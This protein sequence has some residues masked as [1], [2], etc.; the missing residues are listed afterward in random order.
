M[1]QDAEIEDLIQKE[2]D[3]T[4]TQAEA[5]KLEHLI[6]NNPDIRQQLSQSLWLHGQLSADPD[7]INACLE[8]TPDVA[9]NNITYLVFKSFL[10]LAAAVL[11]V[12]IGS[13]L[14]PTPLS[15]A[16]ATLV[17]AE[18]CTWG[19][20]EL[21]TKPNSPLPPGQLELL[22]GI[23]VISFTNGAELVMEAPSN[24]ELLSDMRL[25]LISGSVV[26]DIPEPA[27]GFTVETK[28]GKV[29]DY[30]TRF[31]VS[32][33]E[34]SKPRV[35]VFKGEVEVQDD[36]TQKNKGQRLFEGQ[37]ISFGEMPE[38]LSGEVEL[39]KQF[40]ERSGWQTLEPLKDNYLR[41]GNY[42]IDANSPLLMVKYSSL[43]K[44]NN[45]ITYISFDLSKT[46][47]THLQ[48]AEFVLELQ[49]SGFGF[50]SEIPDCDFTVY[51]VLNDDFDQ[52]DESQLSPLNAPG[53]NPELLRLNKEQ[54]LVLGNFSINRGVSSG[55][56]SIQ[57]DKLANY[58][59]LDKNCIASLLIERDSD[60]LGKQGLVHAFASKEHPNAAPPRLFLKFSE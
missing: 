32:L 55:S 5:D 4:L 30:G 27:V 20:S 54:L 44:N 46:D 60:E 13:F 43:A 1:K 24:V 22:S 38:K 10:A 2:I 51:G 11:L 41:H 23:A 56:V 9:R 7:K 39:N 3:G 16:V 40:Y 6:K 34:F 57:T 33:T 42:P 31:G 29:I 26:L 18:N 48:K 12:W 19:A 47:L 58:L 8:T 35:W 14:Q 52:W 49:P 45:R 36:F 21:P 53:Y 15:K 28:N 25:K 37:S 50:A 17:K 59:K